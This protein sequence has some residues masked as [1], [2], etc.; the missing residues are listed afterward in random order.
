MFK[1]KHNNGLY[2]VK[3]INDR[4]VILVRV[5]DHAKGKAG[6]EVTITKNEF[7]SMYLEVENKK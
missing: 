3:E 2:D 7:F 1:N 6:T 4:E 5:T